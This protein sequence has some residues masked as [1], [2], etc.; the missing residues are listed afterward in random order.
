VDPTSGT[1]GR[2]FVYALTEGD[3][4]HKSSRCLVEAVAEGIVPAAL[5]LQNLLEFLAVVTNP[6][7][8]ARP[9]T[10]EQALK[11]V[12]NLRTTFHVISPR[13]TSL[14]FLS[15]IVRSAG[16]AGPQIFDASWPTSSRTTRLC[17][18]WAA[19]LM[20]A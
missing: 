10:L 9:L 19:T 6:R 4:R 12:T 20:S 18:S 5:F 11:E 14:D 1:H 7:R 8:I 15:G 13:N 3:P 17:R 2:E 16:A